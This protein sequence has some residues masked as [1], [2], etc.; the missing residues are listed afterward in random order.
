MGSSGKHVKREKVDDN[1]L[2][3]EKFSKESSDC[4]WLTANHALRVRFD[5]WQRTVLQGQDIIEGN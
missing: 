4:F 3:N 5:L 1:Q 2:E